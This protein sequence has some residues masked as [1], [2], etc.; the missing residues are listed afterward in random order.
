MS[1]EQRKKV[2]V[3]G[4][5][6][7]DIILISQNK[8]LDPNRSPNYDLFNRDS[9]KM[10][11]RYGGTHALSMLFKQMADFEVLESDTPVEGVGTL[12]EW[13]EKDIII[14]SQGKKIVKKGCF[15]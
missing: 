4:D 11:K 1:G 2:F 10:H 14:E 5:K 13:E 8:H 15:W 7:E 12:S 6:V 9:V 3:L